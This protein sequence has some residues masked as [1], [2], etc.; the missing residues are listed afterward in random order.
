MST[1]NKS[2]VSFKAALMMI[3]TLLAGLVCLQP[4]LAN[5]RVDQEAVELLVLRVGWGL[6]SQGN[7]EAY[8]GRNLA[9]KFYRVHTNGEPGLQSLPAIAPDIADDDLGKV[10]LIYLHVAVFGL[11]AVAT[12]SVQDKDGRGQTFAIMCVGKP[13][14][15]KI[16]ALVAR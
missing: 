6:K 7:A 11:T 1:K 12:A 16:A 15:W 4:A 5:E 8:L 10:A 9:Q 14:G 13:G 2:H 3:G